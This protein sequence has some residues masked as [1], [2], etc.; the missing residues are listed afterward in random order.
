MNTRD[1]RMAIDYS[2]CLHCGACVGT[3]PL[4][5]MFLH[6]VL[7]DFEDNCNQCGICVRVCPVGAIDFPRGHQRSQLR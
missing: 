4:N 7:V 1:A 5:A 6:E 3:C 2:L